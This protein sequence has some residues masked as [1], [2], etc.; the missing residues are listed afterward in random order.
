MYK[1]AGDNDHK[2][3]KQPATESQNQAKDAQGQNLHSEENVIATLQLGLK[4]VT[5]P[6]GAP[7]SILRAGG[8]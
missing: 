5:H 2:T 8:V 3:I 7:I 4:P 1:A 6:P